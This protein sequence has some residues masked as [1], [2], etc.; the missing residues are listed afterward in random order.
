MLRHRAALVALTVIAF[1]TVGIAGPGLF[2][3][4]Y[5]NAGWYIFKGPIVLPRFNVPL[6]DALTQREMQHVGVGYGGF[7]G[8]YSWFGWGY[9]PYPQ[10][11]IRWGY[12][13]IEPPA[14]P[15][16]PAVP[17][18]PRAN[19]T[20]LVPPDAEVWLEGAATH[21]TGP[22]RRFV[23]PELEPGSSYGY[24]VRARWRQGGQVVE[25]TREVV[26]RPGEQVNVAFP[27]QD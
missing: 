5:P 23:S 16:P 21:Q 6:P 2:N 22:V 18:D 7:A 24:T 26:V 12:R 4:N 17:V 11:A 13:G 3:T 19:F 9:G 14:P 1:P 27:K 25:Q 10:A 20:V 8:P 15:L